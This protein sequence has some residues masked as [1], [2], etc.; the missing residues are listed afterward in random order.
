[1]M[2]PGVGEAGVVTGEW[3][4]TPLSV[5]CSPLVPES[6]LTLLSQ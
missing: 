6:G 2:P 4:D 1:M 5:I 3:G